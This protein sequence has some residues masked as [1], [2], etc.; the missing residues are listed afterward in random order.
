MRAVCSKAAVFI[1]I[2][3]HV[4]YG[5]DDGPEALAEMKTMLDAA[6]RDGVEAI[7]A[8][9][10]A[11]PGMHAFDRELC[12]ERLFCARAY[13]QERRYA[14]HVLEGA[15]VLYTSGT[16]HEL[17]NGRIPTLNGTDFV[18]VEWPVRTDAARLSDDLRCLT[19]EGLI[20][21][22]AHAERLRCFWFNP[23][24]LIRLRS[25]LEIRI[26]LNAGA[27]LNPR[28]LWTGR[29]TRRL[30]KEGAADYIASDAHNLSRRKTRMR[31]TYRRVADEY[32]V[33]M[34]RRLM[35]LNQRE[36]LARD[37]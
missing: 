25:E 8:T 11:R 17:S 13:C 19:N 32:G 18:L 23:E 30:L 29:L 24:E 9:P 34:A 7:V 1:D 14:L 3:Q 6:V 37:D 21:V 36:I 26:Q 27:V 33:S 22:I 35:I 5:V 2:H 20:P 4:L 12:R 16:I 15:E 31:E 10:H 28:N